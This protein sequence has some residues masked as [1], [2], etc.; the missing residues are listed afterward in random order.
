MNRSMNERANIRRR[1]L[2]SASAMALLASA[3]GAGVAQA[4]SDD[5]DR[6]QFWIELG[7]QLEQVNGGDEA[8]APPF[9][10]HF[11]PGI[12]SPAK[13]EKQLPWSFGPES[14]ISFEPEGSNWI[15]SAASRYGRAGSRQS[16]HQRS[17]PA[18]LKSIAK[19]HTTAPGNH[20]SLL[21]C[22][23]K[24]VAPN[25]PG[26]ADVQSNHQ[27]SHNIIDFQAGKDV[28]LGLFGSQ[29]SSVFAAGVR[30]AQFTTRMDT[31][32]KARTDLQH[33]NI[34]DLPNYAYFRSFYPQK[35]IPG[36]SFKTHSLTAGSTRSLHAIGPSIAWD[37]SAA[38]MGHRETVQ[39]TVD[40]GVNAAVLFGKQKAS[41]FH[42]SS[43]H[44]GGRYGYTSLYNHPRT[45]HIRS[46]TVI[47]PNV[48]GM[49]GLSIRFPNAKV[50]LGYRADVFF[51]AMDAG[52][53]S[54]KVENRS[55]F[56]PFASVS[57]GFG[58]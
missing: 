1:F 35:Y 49:A 24:T 53:D 45:N 23:T 8:F 7:A 33:Y 54:R 56:G 25:K 15:F 55:F 6:P 46:R 2:A 22:H 57:V 34:M 41:T 31:S 58:G 12:T 29:S 30:F 47:V 11:G 5:T 20:Y 42:Q 37:A 39:F 44:N 51:S 9:F 18:G 3:F 14:K 17:N 26:F 40:W 48:G 38:L 13:T 10:G 21:C 36:T 50:S 32:I 27:E 16:T 52:W 19:Y 43:A 28:G 4:A